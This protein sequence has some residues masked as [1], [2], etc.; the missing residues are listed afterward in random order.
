VPEIENK[1][2]KNDS[3]NL[4]ENAYVKAVKFV[5][6]ALLYKKPYA[7]LNDLIR[8]NIKN[9]DYVKIYD[10]IK[11]QYD[12]NNVPKVSSLFDM[13]EVEDNSDVYDIANYEFN[14]LEDNEKYYNDCM[15]TLVSYGLLVRQEEVTNRLKETKDNNE[16]M[17][18]AKEL[19]ELITKRKGL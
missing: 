13:F 10:Y 15:T 7:I 9:G 3:I 18:L 6:S 4:K 11:L 12:N 8:E 1:P 5:I 19:Q 16:R 2:A 14:P 17:R